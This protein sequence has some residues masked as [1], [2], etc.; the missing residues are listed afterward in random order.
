MKTHLPTGLRKALI[1]AIFAVS[2]VAYNAQADLV[3]I[4]NN[5]DG[6]AETWSGADYDSTGYSDLTF[7]GTN[8]TIA[9]GINHKCHDYNATGI[10]HYRADYSGSS[11]SITA[12]VSA[13]GVFRLYSIDV[14]DADGTNYDE[15]TYSG[16]TY[17]HDHS[18]TNDFGYSTS[19]S[20]G[21]LTVKDSAIVEVSAYVDAEG[22]IN[23][24][25][26]GILTSANGNIDAEDGITATGHSVLKA[27]NGDI[28]VSGGDITAS[29]FSRIN[30]E[31]GTVSASGTVKAD[32]TNS[33]VTA[34]NMTG[35]N[36]TA[37]SGGHLAATNMTGDVT[38]TGT[39]SAVSATT[40]SGDVTAQSAGA[41]NATN[42][43]GDVLADGAGSEVTATTITGDVKAK[44]AGTVNATTITGS[45]TADNATLNATT[46]TNG[47][48]AKNGGT[49]TA[50]NISGGAYTETNGTIQ[51]DKQITGSVS[52]S[53]GV[54]AATAGQGLTITDSLAADG[55]T[56]I[57]GAGETVTIGTTGDGNISGDGNFIGSSADHS[58]VVASNI[59]VKGD[60]SGESNKLSATGTN[61]ADG[62]NAIAADAISGN[63][64]TLRVTDYGN[65]S[66]A[67]DIDGS[68]NT[69]TIEDEGDMSVGGD[70][71]GS[72]N[73][74]TIEGLGNM[75]V[76]G[77]IDGSSNTLTIECA[78]D[79]SV[80]GD[81]NGGSNA[82]VIA[83]EGDMSV[84]GDING[85]SNALTI[86]GE[87]DITIGGN[88]WGDSNQLTI[89]GD[90]DIFLQ[91]DIDGDDNI[92]TVKGDGNISLSHD[93]DGDGNT[94]TVEGNGDIQIEDLYGDG[95]SL[96][97]KGD[98]DMI[99]DDIYGDDNTLT[100]EG[101]GDISLLADIDGEGNI[102][103]VKGD[104]NISLSGN[105]DGDD[106]TLTVEGNGDIYAN[107]VDSDGN[108]LTVKGD[109]DVSV[110]D[111]EGDDN[112]LTI[113]GDGSVI[114]ENISGN[115]NMLT[116]EGEGDIT[117]GTLGNSSSPAADNKLTAAQGDITIDELTD[118]TGLK[119]TATD[120]TVTVTNDSV[121]TL[122]ASD[123]AA[124]KDITIGGDTATP[125][126]LTLTGD[127]TVTSEE[128]NVTLD[129][130]VTIDDAAIEATAG[131]VTFAGGSNTVKNG[132]TVTAGD[133]IDVAEGA[134]LNMGADS[135]DALVGKLSGAGSISAQHDDL[136]LSYDDTAFTG[137]I[138]MGNGKTLTISDKGVG[139]DATISLTAG[140]TALVV[141]AADA[142][143]GHVQAN[144]GTQVSL[145][146]GTADGTATAST[147]TM[148]NAST[149]H[150][151]A[152]ATS[153]DCITV[154]ESVSIAQAGTVYVNNQTSL[155]DIKGDVSHA[156][157]KLADGAVNNGVSEDV[158]YDMAGGQRELQGKNMSLVS[159]EDGVQLVISDNFR[160]VEGTS[161]NQTAV[162][163]TMKAL[164]AAADHS[165]STLAD[166]ASELDNILDALDNTRSTAT[167]VQALQ[168]LS[169]AGNLVVPN[170]M[171]DTTRHH[172]S[173]LRSHMGTPVCTGTK[174]GVKK[175]GNAW[176]AYTGGHDAI[177]GDVTGDYTRTHQGAILGSDYSVTCNTSVGVSLGYENSIGR[178]DSTKAESDTVFADLYATV[179][180]G[181]LTHRFSAG[182]AL[183]DVDVT[184]GLA[185]A[186]GG[187][188]Y[189]G[190]STGSMDA[191]T[192]NLGYEISSD[193]KLSEVST[194]TP[195]AT[196]D[197]AFHQLD[198]L[199]ESGQGDASVTTNYD[200]PV[201]LD[202]ALG[203]AYTRTFRSFTADSSALTV[204]AALHGELSKHRP[205]ADNHFIGGGQS[206]K[207]RSSERTPIYGEIGASVAIPVYKTTSVIGGGNFEFSE[208][209][210]S[211]GGNVGLNV[212]F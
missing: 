197:L 114:A 82:L 155:E 47:A 72:N 202:V 195:F 58:T 136:H 128:G 31:N 142:S 26:H 170:M 115:G 35:T 126:L 144:P 196:V 37:K 43:T 27:D 163:D 183:S 33:S 210:I 41:V 172:L 91:S 207:T 66:I 87:G 93:I 36:L 24:N 137:L 151:D 28:R 198:T 92:V 57:T 147:L 169:A 8:E 138:D 200:D 79:M 121:A 190:N 120:G 208:D 7:S 187:H 194:L 68:G 45:A 206:W 107:D 48:A 64:N 209:R 25:N 42:I 167:T 188:T 139:A 50:T 1:A 90:G 159:T 67:N 199:T 30:A 100:I 150:I 179:K 178:M 117:I 2:A 124:K 111:I 156:V 211:V 40:I 191:V 9:S 180:Q 106:N 149:L 22:A 97:I 81:I 132:A 55:D 116:T 49:L 129:Q 181:K 16:E 39:G 152:D 18:S 15:T 103:T 6:S 54:I 65:V 63:T 62:T 189:T 88:V 29:D 76:G 71:D 109:G 12:P 32:G 86:M 104:G 38:A 4:S 131:K 110:G 96:T 14:Y 94:L 56:L 135:A 166:S 89:G 184:R 162:N 133:T 102:V 70:I 127:T 101:N 69:L 141:T 118:N 98:G 130:N 192:W 80:G 182:V 112:T 176:V 77:D 10:P 160:G 158:R 60:I 168:S 75:S 99:T 204:S 84:G 171:M 11:T 46:I 3:Q 51:T 175:G 61:L 201:Q 52:G 74:L 164:S 165:G 20:D 154:T 174:A 140:D 108:S 177:N 34:V 148:Q 212:K 119:V 125:A 153:A 78:G 205:T 161:A 123:I 134:T 105:I 145:N 21:N 83:G 5:S 95:N 146:P 53:N 44:D 113:A 193:M 85:S 19:C 157:I 13:D 185:I 143:I 23:L 17:S 186:A 73:A 173:T 122:T 203:A 59:Q